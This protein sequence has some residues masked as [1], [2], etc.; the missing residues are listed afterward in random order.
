MVSN[1]LERDNQH[2]QEMM[3]THE[4]THTHTH[5]NTL[6][7]D[8]TQVVKDEKVNHSVVPMTTAWEARSL[9][10]SVY[11]ETAGNRCFDNRD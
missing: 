8:M 2:H 3:Y 11:Y 10:T 1:M 7:T 9:A 4:H 6:L 5:T